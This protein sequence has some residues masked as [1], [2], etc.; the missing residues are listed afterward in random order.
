MSNHSPP[1]NRIKHPLYLGQFPYRPRIQIRRVVK[2]KGR[3][4]LDCVVYRDSVPGAIFYHES[5]ESFRVIDE[6]IAEFHYDRMEVGFVG[7][8]S[9]ANVTS[10]TLHILGQLN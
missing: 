7:E 6:S 4:R 10:T 9:R 8:G 1:M 2:M 5:G 3:R